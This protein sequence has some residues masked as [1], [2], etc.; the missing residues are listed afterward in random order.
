MT[1][2]YVAHKNRMIRSLT[3]LVCLIFWIGCQP[4][5]ENK[6]QGFYRDLNKNGKLDIYEDRT[7]TIDDRIEDLLAQMKIEEKAGLLFN[8]ISGMEFGE[9][10][11]RA[12][13]LISQVM[14]N[15][16]D[17]PGLA[18]ARQLYDLNDTLQRIAEST[19]LGI[20]ITFYSDPRQGLRYNE[21]A[22][23]NRFHS[24]WPSELG[25][26]AIGS[27]D[28]V[29]EFGDISR[30]EYLALGI[31]LALHPMADLATEP[32]WFRSYTTFGEDAD[33]STKLLKA[34]IEGF[35]GKEINENSVLT[36][37]KHFPGGGP[38]KDGMDAHFPSGKE[39][40]YPGGMFNYHLKPFVE[41]AL[42]AGTA[43]MM[44]YYGVPVGI[45]EEQ[46]AFGYNK[47]I[48]TDLLR[49]SLGFKG[50]VCTDWALVFDN[51]AKP[52]S[53][54]GVE[55]L[56]PKERVKKIIDAGVDMFGGESCA[57]LVVE[58]VKEGS[59]P[60][61]RIDQSVSR[62]LRDKFVL[63]LFDN[64]YPAEEGLAVFDNMDFKE[65]GREAQRKSLI[66]LK[67]KEN[68]LPLSKGHKVYVKGM[69]SKVFET[70]A[71]VV[72][73]P[74]EADFNIIKF[75]TPYTPVEAP[76]FFLERTFQQGRLDFPEDEKQ[77]LL[78]LMSSK[79]TI[80]IFTMLRPAVFPEIN[81]ASQALIVDFECEDDILA[82][83]VFGKF[84]PTGKLPI[85]IPSSIM[86]VE[87]QKE[88][89]PKDSKNPLYPF[90]YGL[91][92]E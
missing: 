52:A 89:V 10:I 45:T 90:G 56:S 76:K 54:W 23:K 51:P 41:G 17:M 33:L 72:K 42:P 24:R 84:S 32:R 49:D 2:T 13:S 37:T 19:R 21:A 62:I 66:L 55:T 43:Q 92:F 12:D 31:R 36:M 50:V 44:L 69:D 64:P 63:G 86:A 7:Q 83:L 65:K 34:Y 29:K 35:Q 14:I 20:P 6:E 40:V 8:A 74:K 59:V 18:T 71:E 53:A 38:Q 27:P 91:H 67:N 15:H 9:R 61:S 1:N 26:A 57:E 80:S 78:T 87:E 39:Q 88:D 30:Q 81:A 60:E 73:D 85:E 58:L 4:A 5:S 11:E 3:V 70:Y 79:P 28:V 46:V 82:E 16:L 22:G 75:G 68:T 47:E 48:V 77:E 25:F